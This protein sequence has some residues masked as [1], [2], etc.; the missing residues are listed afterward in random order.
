MIFRRFF[1]FGALSHMMLFWFEMRLYC[2]CFTLNV[3][4][5][6]QGA[7]LFFIMLIF[8]QDIAFCFF[9]FSQECF[10]L[11]LIEQT[12]LLNNTGLTE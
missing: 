4:I 8:E 1:F 7:S 9:F 6:T 11:S 12:E 3:R 5:L 10:L 2:P